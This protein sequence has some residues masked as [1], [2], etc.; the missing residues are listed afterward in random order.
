MENDAE[1][2]F[3]SITAAENTRKTHIYALLL[4]RKFTG[5][6]ISEIVRQREE[7]FKSKDPA[8]RRRLEA[9]VEEFYNWLTEGRELSFN[10]AYIYVLSIKA[11]LGHYDIHL[12][13][14]GIKRA[15]TLSDWIPSV[16]QLKEMYEIGDLNEKT[17]LAV[18][19]DVP[20]LINDFNEI[21]KK[22]IVPLLN[23]SE[24]PV[25]FIKTTVKKRPMACFITQETARILRKYVG[26]L[27]DDNPYLFQGR[28]KKKLSEDSINR[29]L[30]N[31][32]KKAGFNT[33]GL[34][35]RFYMFR[36]VFTETARDAGL[37]LDQIKA[38]LGK[39][40]QIHM[41]SQYVLSELKPLFEKIVE[42]LRLGISSSANGRR[43]DEMEHNVKTLT[44]ALVALL[45]PRVTEA[46]AELKLTWPKRSS[47]NSG[48]IALA[49][50]SRNQHF[51]VELKDL[52]QEEVIELY[53]ELMKRV[54]NRKR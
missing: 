47:E 26:T 38:L 4:F 51:G 24:F 36:K 49:P 30:R 1:D 2:F 25:F 33:R 22:D 54:S 27:R 48:Y 41:T 39:K 5:K 10:T 53:L 19:T 35:V 23:S 37:S 16:E 52:R 3:D 40:T 6:T 13:L 18:A 21:L 44:E 46:F 20:M 7:D 17:L 42:K 34:R 14:K 11:I 29:T 8:A 45:R 28:G 9:E 31:L 12:K 15:P 43:L 32:V 50:D